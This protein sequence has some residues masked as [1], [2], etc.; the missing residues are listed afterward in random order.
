MGA[1][2]RNIAETASFE[3]RAAFAGYVLTKTLSIRSAM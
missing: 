2:A 1:M 3:G